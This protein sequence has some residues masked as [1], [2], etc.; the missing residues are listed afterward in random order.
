[1][2][3]EPHPIRIAI[4]CK[5]FLFEAWEAEAIRQAISLPFVKVVLLVTEDTENQK[6]ASFLSWIFNYPYRNMLW[7]FYK[8]FLLR[9]PAIAV[10]R[11][12]NE[13]KE[14]PVI[15]CKPLLKGKYSQHFSPD[16]LAKLASYQP[17]VILRFGFNILRGGIL[18]LAK[19]GVWS[20]H[21]AD[22]G[23][24]R[25]GPAAFWEIRRKNPV[26]GAVLQRLTDKLDAGI[27]LRNGFFHTINRS[28]SSNLQQLLW[29]TTTWIRQALLDV[30][31]GI[32]PAENGETLPATAPVH[33]WP[34]NHQ[35]IRA[36]FITRINKIR[37]HART[38]FSPEKW[39][40]ALVNQ[41]M[42]SIISEGITGK[43]EWH[44]EAPS[45][46]YYADPF[47]WAENGKTKII[48][49]HYSYKN[50]RGII[51]EKENSAIKPL[52]A[53]PF[54]ISYPFVLKDRDQ[55]KIIPETWESGKL[56]MVDIKMVREQ[57]ELPDAA[58][59]NMNSLQVIMDDF[60][61]VD[62]TPVLWKNRWWLFCTKAGEYSNTALYIF[63]SENF[64]GPWQPHMNNPVK[65]DI[66]SA[67][68]GGTPFEMD[69]KLF[70]PA[71]DCSTTYGAAVVLQEITELTES[72]FSEVIH[73][74][75]EPQGDWKYNR[76][77]HTFSVVD[78]NHVLIDAK[79]YAFNFDNFSHALS[80][81]MR[82]LTGK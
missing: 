28:Y 74:R 72:A 76:G 36:W 57:N 45:G 63:H 47:G 62:A 70:R 53:L 22:A 52:L 9:V 78:E 32:S 43:I 67:R 19:Y 13:L 75:M 14:I 37:F 24:L 4:L 42:N 41:S 65:W 49:E 21:H 20:Y 10:E 3:T 56:F 82:R 33:S 60:P 77:L 55:L 18:I 71:Q 26:T 44:P 39:N 38:L 12:Y 48:F 15:K 6:P 31:H 54:H 29:G 51:S 69:G 2:H 40:V 81:K 61:A 59:K 30:R 8:R 79:R 66:R 50:Q 64:S 46:E 68:P 25:G 17:D 27:V 58:E 1:M 73:R 7:R 5:G 35:M 16:D 23:F 80:R 34:R 11:L